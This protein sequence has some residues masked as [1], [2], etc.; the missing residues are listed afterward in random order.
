MGESNT[1]GA[2]LMLSSVPQLVLDLS[3]KKPW[4]NC[5][6]EG[7]GGTSWGGECPMDR[8]QMQEKVRRG[9]FTS[10]GEKMTSHLRSWAEWQPEATPIGR[11]LKVIV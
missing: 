10:E 7:I 6:A 9:E 8:R 1:V 2:V 4:A 11:W 3:V 5:W